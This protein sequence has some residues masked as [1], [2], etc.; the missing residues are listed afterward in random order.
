ME[1]TR[2]NK[3]CTIECKNN[4]QALQYSLSLANKLKSN[5]VKFR[6]EVVN[7]HNRIYYHFVINDNYV[8]IY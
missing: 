3:W 2:T 1:K 4:Y 5:N 7:R 6:Y 8:N